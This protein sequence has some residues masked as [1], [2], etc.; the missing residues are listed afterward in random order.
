LSV[1]H[2]APPTETGAEL[3]PFEKEFYSKFISLPQAPNIVRLKP[4]AKRVRHRG[5]IQRVG[6]ISYDVATVLILFLVIGF[7]FLC[8]DACLVYSQVPTEPPGPVETTPLLTKLLELFED[9]PIW[10]RLALLHHFDDNNELMSVLQLMPY[11]AFKFAKGPWRSCYVRYGYCRYSRC[12]AS[13]DLSH[14]FS[15]PF[16][17]D[18]R[19][20][21][22]ARFLQTV[23]L[24]IKRSHAA[25]L[26][27]AEPRSSG[28]T[29]TAALRAAKHLKATDPCVLS[30][31]AS[32]QV[33]QLVID[34]FSSETLF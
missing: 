31:P 9:R 8:V 20:E 12:T 23:E 30:V 24:R 32:R 27:I 1:R 10:S 28:D 25:M 26:K 16:R 19:I 13:L 4:S 29:E 33:I 11:V 22:E 17:Y 15:L 21:P 7:I 34:V 3:G 2:S 18:P 14:F 5:T 6:Y